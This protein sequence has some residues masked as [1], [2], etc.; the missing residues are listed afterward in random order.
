M[1]NY[2]ENKQIHYTSIWLF[3][4]TRNLIGIKSHLTGQTKIM[5]PE[6]RNIRF[7]LFGC[8]RIFLFKKYFQK[9]QYAHTTSTKII[10][11]KIYKSFLFS[12]YKTKTIQPLYDSNAWKKREIIT[13]KKSNKHY[14]F[15]KVQNHLKMTYFV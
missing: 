6:D 12:F 1:N 10:K 2:D 4:K 3:Y 14:C 7:N 15:Q 13:L 8:L 11:S 5:S 9:R